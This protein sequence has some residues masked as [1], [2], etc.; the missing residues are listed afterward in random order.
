MTAIPA[1]DELDPED[2]AVL[3]ATARRTAVHLEL[4]DAYTPN[5]PL[6]LRWLA[7]KV[8]PED[9]AADERQWA[10]LIRATVARGVTVR[11]LRVVSEPL[12]P[13]TRFEYDGAGA[14]NEAAGEQVRWLPRRRASDLCLPG[15][16]FWLL[17][18]RLVRFGYFSGI[19]DYLGAELTTEPSVAKHCSTSFEAAWDRAIPHAEYEPK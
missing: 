19:G 9:I 18:D 16:D 15:N 5:D 11:R 2:F 10:E 8:G 6:F 4:R 3:F 13:F 7:G 1:L 17:D 12:A 14:L